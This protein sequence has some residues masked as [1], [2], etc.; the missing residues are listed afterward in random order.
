M[1]AFIGRRSLWLDEALTAWVA[2]LDAGMFAEV[3][4]GHSASSGCT[5]C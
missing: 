4:P 5:T 1:F 3:I 2:G